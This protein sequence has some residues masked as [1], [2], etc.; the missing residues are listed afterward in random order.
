M[1]LVRV[2]MMSRKY[3]AIATVFLEMCRYS[4]AVNLRWGAIRYRKSSVWHGFWVAIEVVV[5]NGR[6]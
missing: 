5:I 2:Y 4:A 3:C 6:R 1:Q